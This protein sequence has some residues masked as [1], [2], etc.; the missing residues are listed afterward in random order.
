MTTPT[1]AATVKPRIAHAL[2][3][4]GVMA[5]TL[6]LSAQAQAC[7]A[8]GEFCGQPTWAANAFSGPF[9]RVPE[10]SSASRHYQVISPSK[11]VTSEKVIAVQKV[12]PLVRF[13]DGLGRQFDAASNVWFDGNG[14]CWSGRKPFTFKGGDWFYGAKE[15][16]EEN[17]VW[18]VESGSA[19]ELVSCE[20]VPSFAA[21]AAAI[22]AKAAAQ[23]AESPGKGATRQPAPVTPGPAKIKTAEGDPAVAVQKPVTPASAECRKYFASIGQMLT[24]PCGE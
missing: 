9:N 21:K 10:A 11:P 12:A 1:C 7:N 15:W 23:K 14:Q 8:R 20:S 24:V 6:G 16:A 18:E 2:L 13:A 5:T 19:P 3:V 4:L 22:A 17:G